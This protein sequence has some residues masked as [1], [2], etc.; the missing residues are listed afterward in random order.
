MKE[1]VFSF[2]DKFG[3]QR[4]ARHEGATKE[5]ATKAL[6]AIEPGIKKILAYSE[7]DDTLS[8]ILDVLHQVPDYDLEMVKKDVEASKKERAAAAEK[9]RLRKLKFKKYQTGEDTIS[10]EWRKWLTDEVLKN[11]EK[12]EL[13]QADWNKLLTAL[14][15]DEKE[16][17]Y[18]Q[19][20]EDA[21]KNWKDDAQSL[22]RE[23]QFIDYIFNKRKGQKN[24]AMSI[25]DIAAQWGTSHVYVTKVSKKAEEKVIKEI[26]RRANYPLKIKSFQ[27][28]MKLLMSDRA[29]R[30][31]QD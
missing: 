21:E 26:A 12:G 11:A 2:I 30:K 14:K 24:K 27:D 15:D 10:D 5:E 8:K 17:M 28:A 4:I 3:K 22:A 13:S 29:A 18:K 7:V 16:E 31:T 9:E 1:F 25:R 6:Q 23:K 20:I 19:F